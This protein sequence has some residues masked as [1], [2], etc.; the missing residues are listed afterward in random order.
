M[1]GASGSNI[2]FTNSVKHFFIVIRLTC[3]VNAVRALGLAAVV[4]CQLD[5]ARRAAGEQPLLLAA[6][7]DRGRVLDVRQEVYGEV[8]LRKIHKLPSVNSIPQVESANRPTCGKSLWMSS[9]MPRT[10]V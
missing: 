3:I 7:W 6:R 9:V 5:A 8:E 2:I 1:F 4:P 10:L